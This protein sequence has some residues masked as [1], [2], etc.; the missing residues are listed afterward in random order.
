VVATINAGQTSGISTSYQV[1]SSRV[2]P[3]ATQLLSTGNTMMMGRPLA[4]AA[5]SYA[6]MVFS[7]HGDGSSG[8]LALLEFKHL[9]QLCTGH[10]HSTTAFDGAA[11]PSLHSHYNQPVC[12]I[13]A[14][15]IHGSWRKGAGQRNRR[16]P[17]LQLGVFVVPYAASHLLWTG[18]L[19]CD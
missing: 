12:D 16:R 4:V 2:C 7:S 3:S 18:R 13:S 8:L 1:R 11:N 6:W 19:S 10:L 17:H 5:Y 14:F 15:L 9:S